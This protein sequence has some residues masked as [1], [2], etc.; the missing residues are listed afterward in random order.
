MPD[1]INRNEG[2]DVTGLR[3]IAPGESISAAMIL[4]VQSRV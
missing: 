4:A 3:V 1:A 2:G